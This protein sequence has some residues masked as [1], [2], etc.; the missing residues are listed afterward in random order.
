M[1]KKIMKYALYLLSS[2]SATFMTIKPSL[3]YIKDSEVFSKI[4]IP[5]STITTGFLI[6][7]NAITE[8]YTIYQLSDSNKS[9][10]RISLILG[11]LSTFPTFFMQFILEEEN[12]P[13]AITTALITFFGS[14][15]LQALG[16]WDYFDKIQ[17]HL[18]LIKS[19]LTKKNSTQQ[20]K[21]ML[22]NY[23][24]YLKYLD[25]GICSVLYHEILDN[26]EHRE[27]LLLFDHIV[28]IQSE[29]Q[30]YTRI[31]QKIENI[32]SI[33][34]TVGILL[35]ESI[36]I[37]FIIATY[38]SLKLA[39]PPWASG[40]ITGIISSPM[41]ILSADYGYNLLRTLTIKIF[42][43]CKSFYEYYHTNKPIKI[44]VPLIAIHP[45]IAFLTFF[46][47]ILIAS[48]SYAALVQFNNEI[49]SDLLSETEL[50]FM[51]LMTTAGGLIFN[52]YAVTS[53]GEKIVFDA[54]CVYPNLLI[55]EK[56]NFCKYILDKKV[57][58]RDTIRHRFFS[59]QSLF[60]DAKNKYLS[61]YEKVNDIEMVTVELLKDEEK[62][63]DN[64]YHI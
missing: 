59:N 27:P 3:K 49:L 25:D 55:K 36:N 47:T 46:T 53:I 9:N 20:M 2:F 19:Y 56:A 22:K 63:N 23:N 5:T 54:L 57:S 50:Y 17:P 45:V 18:Y 62:V 31:N 26:Y 41:I 33:F 4:T 35:A 14:I 8:I 30:T 24:D 1:F 10:I 28:N 15:S 58:H 32:A 29:M 11:T 52:V 39:M 40:I 34:G 61:G 6:N 21:E 12:V 7:L 43:F 13:Y 38:Q 16:I 64:A 60:E 37:S 51:N 48:R 44:N 42:E